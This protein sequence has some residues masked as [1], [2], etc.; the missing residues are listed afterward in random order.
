MKCEVRDMEKTMDKIV[1]AGKGK[2]ICISR[3]PTF[4]VDL[5]IPGIMEISVWN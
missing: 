4:M 2:R 1:A 3:V 5:R